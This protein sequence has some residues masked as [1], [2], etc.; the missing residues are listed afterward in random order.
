MWYMVVEEA[1]VVVAILEEVRESVVD[2]MGV[3]EEVEG[4]H[5]AMMVV[6]I[7]MK[8]EEFPTKVVVAMVVG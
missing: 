6:D 7:L 4:F 5:Q 8:V 2:T 3:E 1:M